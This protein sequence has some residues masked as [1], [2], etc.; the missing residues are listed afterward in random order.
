MQCNKLNGKFLKVKAKVSGFLI[1]KI[2]KRATP[3]KAIVVT[4]KRK[5]NTILTSG[6]Q[7]LLNAFQTYMSGVN[8][9]GENASSPGIV[10]TTSSGQTITLSF[11]TPPAVSATSNSAIISFTVRDASTNSYTATSEELITTSAGYNIPIATANLSVTKN[12]DEILTL[13][14]VITISI[15]PSSDLAYIPTPAPQ[16]GGI[17]GCGCINSQCGYCNLS[18]YTHYGNNSCSL[19]GLSQKYQQSNFVT[20]QL[21]TDMFYNNYG[22]GSSNPLTYSYGTTLII[23]A[24]YCLPYFFVGAVSFIT[25]DSSRVISC[26]TSGSPVTPVYLQIYSPSETAPYIGVQ[27]EFTT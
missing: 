24:N 12:S 8:Y 6:L 25:Y 11:L 7:D 9:V 14:W 18:Y 4:V 15:S 27:I 23:Y 22:I 17:S 10:I 1:A 2:E 3:E 26:C 19:A 13:T 5:K 16:S 20:T 21:F